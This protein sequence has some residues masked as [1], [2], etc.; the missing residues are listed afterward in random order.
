MPVSRWRNIK[1]ARAEGSLVLKNRWGSPRSSG[2]AI[3]YVRVVAPNS[4]TCTLNG[5][6][7]WGF[8]RQLLGAVAGVAGPAAPDA[9]REPPPVLWSVVWLASRSAAD[10]VDERVDENAQ[11]QAFRAKSRAR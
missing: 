9:P 1:G 5:D 3:P 8:R 11:R 10:H 6:P 7:A 4:P 2:G